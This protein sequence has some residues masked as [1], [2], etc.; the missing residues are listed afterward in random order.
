M[1][2]QRE[3]DT[4]PPVDHK[5]QLARIVLYPAPRHANTNTGKWQLHSNAL[6]AEAR[7]LLPDSYP[8]NESSIK[9]VFVT[10]KKKHEEEWQRIVTEA[11]NDP[12]YLADI[13]SRF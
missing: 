13:V 6:F 12:N 1:V 8:L 10:W 2:I 3:A 5:K 11:G 7:G 4:D 9:T